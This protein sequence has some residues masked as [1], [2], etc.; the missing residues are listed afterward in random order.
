[1]GI[2]AFRSNVFRESYPTGSGPA[3]ELV[4]KVRET[5]CWV[6]LVRRFSVR[7]VDLD[8]E[9]EDDSDMWHARVIPIRRLSVDYYAPDVIPLN[10]LHT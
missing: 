3:S 10:V 1:V 7:G 5:G 2:G 8:A 6:E 9:S 4:G